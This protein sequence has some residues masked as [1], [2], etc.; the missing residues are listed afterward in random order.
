MFSFSF[1]EEGCNTIVMTLIVK[2]KV[3]LFIEFSTNVFKCLLHHLYV[4]EY[5]DMF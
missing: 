1:F 3:K 2:E 5:V 4:Y